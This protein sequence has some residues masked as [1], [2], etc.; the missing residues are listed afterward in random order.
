M[1]I[2]KIKNLA[3]VVAALGFLLLLTELDGGPWAGT[4]IGA[5]L[6]MLGALAA[7]RTQKIISARRLQKSRERDHKDSKQI[8]RVA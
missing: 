5:A 4:F 6:F 1:N 2:S 7:L 8:D 3:A